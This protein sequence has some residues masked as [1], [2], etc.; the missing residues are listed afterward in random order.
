M[1]GFLFVPLFLM[2]Y[3]V[4]YLVYNC[5]AE[6]GGAVCFTLYSCYPVNVSGV[7]LFLGI[8]DYGISSSYTQL[9]FKMIHGT[10]IFNKTFIH[11]TNFKK[12]LILSHHFRFHSCTSLLVCFCS[13]D[14]QNLNSMVTWCISLRRL[15]ALII[16]QRS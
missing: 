5:L 15:L 10:Y 1:F 6:E 11:E 2:Q 16:C 13:K 12:L 7:C 4:S 9:F 14:F 8:C 3:L